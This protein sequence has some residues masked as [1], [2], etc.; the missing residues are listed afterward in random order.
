MRFSFSTLVSQDGSAAFC[1]GAK[2]A[3]NANSN[4]HED[5]TSSIFP[6]FTW[7]PIELRHKRTARKSVSGPWPDY[8]YQP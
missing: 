5:Q 6:D 1:L 2:R 8:R 4:A 3:K 7:H